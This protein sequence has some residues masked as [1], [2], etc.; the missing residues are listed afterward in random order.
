MSFH[1]D[2]KDHAKICAD[3]RNQ[4]SIEDL[5]TKRKL[6]SEEVQAEDE[7][8]IVDIIEVRHHSDKFEVFNKIILLWIH[9]M[10]LK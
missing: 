10:F 1:E 3:H 8:Q 5:I 9:N 6:S 2:S 7:Q 4:S